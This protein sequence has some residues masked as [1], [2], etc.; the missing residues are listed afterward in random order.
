MLVFVIVQASPPNL[1]ST[2][3]Y[4]KYFYESRALGEA[5]YWWSQFVFAIE[6]IKTMNPHVRG[7]PSK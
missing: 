6:F 2:V 7:P 4:I 3:Q 1:L 5:M